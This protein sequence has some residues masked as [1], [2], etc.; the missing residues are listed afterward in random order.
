M[1][2][3][4]NFKLCYSEEQISQ[5]VSKIGSSINSW[6]E[7]TLETTGQD[8]I[9]VPILRGGIFF[10]SDLVREITYSLEIAPVNAW[11]YV[12]NANQQKL[13]H[14]SVDISGVSPTGRH[15]LLVD[16][17][18]D[19]GETLKALEQAFF[20][21]GALEVKTATLIKRN[22]EESVFDP[23]WKGFEY[24]GLDWFVGYGMDD[25]SRWRN[26]GSVY[27]IEKE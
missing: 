13:D 26:L 22:I 10:F 3:P 5:A 7:K 24:D 12:K 21:A 6:A 20:D 11:A 19:S 16:D 17:I 8:I 1:N 23:E 25:A 2:I 15:V 4:N 18:C 27:I 9:A 14:V